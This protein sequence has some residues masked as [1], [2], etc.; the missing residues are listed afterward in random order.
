MVLGLRACCLTGKIGRF[1]QSAD[2]TTL[3]ISWNG[4]AQCYGVT[5]LGFG[6]HLLFASF[7]LRMTAAARFGEGEKTST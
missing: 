3:V 5:V 2:V 1:L 4:R 7:L 6:F